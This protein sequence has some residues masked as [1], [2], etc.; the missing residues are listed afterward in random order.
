M[1]TIDCIGNT[2]GEATDVVS[3]FG[4][5][6]KISKNMHTNHGVHFLVCIFPLHALSM[7]RRVCNIFFSEHFFVRFFPGNYCT[8]VCIAVSCALCT[9]RIFRPSFS[10]PSFWGS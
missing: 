3:F 4:E 10:L 7:H 1:P 6:S 8:I 2:P 5:N 9:V